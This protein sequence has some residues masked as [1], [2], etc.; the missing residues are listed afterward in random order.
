MADRAAHRVLD[1]WNDRLRPA[2]E[3]L[4]RARWEAACRATPAAREGVEAAAH[5]LDE[6]CHDEVGF[7]RVEQSLSERIDDPLLRRALERL[8]LRLLPHRQPRPE[9]LVALEAEVQAY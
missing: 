3:A 5:A 2:S 8:R 9:A 4:A 1:A 7:Q 6:L